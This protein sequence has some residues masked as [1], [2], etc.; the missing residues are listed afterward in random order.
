MTSRLRSFLISLGAV[1]TAAA[2]AAGPSFDCSKAKLWSEIQVCEN[3]T[4]A[5]LDREGA[6]LFGGA[7]K[8][9]RGQAQRQL[10]TDQKAWLLER[11]RCR[12][13]SDPTRCLLNVYEKRIFQ[14]KASTQSAAANKVVLTERLIAHVCWMGN[15]CVNEYLI[16]SIRH[17]DQVKVRIRDVTIVDGDVKEGKPENRNISCKIEPHGDHAHA[18]EYTLWMAVCKGAKTQWSPE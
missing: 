15:E 5:V 13:Q 9:L 14:L 11:E 16:S 10:I 3:A 2:H 17:N 8:G 7:K 18:V 1:I 4:L 12:Q 6:T